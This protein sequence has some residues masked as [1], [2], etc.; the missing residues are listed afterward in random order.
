MS[1]CN[2]EAKQPP[3]WESVVTYDF[4]QSR[5]RYSIRHVWVENTTL[6]KR[7]AVGPEMRSSSGNPKRC[8]ECL[9]VLARIEWKRYTFEVQADALG[10]ER[11][12]LCI[13]DKPWNEFTGP[14][15]KGVIALLKERG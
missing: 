11:V 9:R 6:C 1:P 2:D 5:R 14:V 4:R 7:H 8:P 13:D 3:E 10:C 15:A 12:L